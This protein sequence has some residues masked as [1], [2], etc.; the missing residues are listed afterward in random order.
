MRNDIPNMVQ[1]LFQMQ[2][3][4]LEEV[5]NIFPRAVGEAVEREFVKNIESESF[6]DNPYPPLKMPRRDGSTDHILVDTGKGKQ[7][8]STSA[9]PSIISEGSIKINFAIE[10]NVKYM[11]YHNTG[12]GNNP[13]REF[14]GE[15]PAITEAVNEEIEKSLNRINNSI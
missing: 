11:Y 9:Q 6:N 4:N 13:Q 1:A 8:V 10:D 2:A 15:S 12:T 3:A 7:A 5:N 14:A